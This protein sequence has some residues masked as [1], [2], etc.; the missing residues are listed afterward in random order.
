MTFITRYSY[1]RSERFLKK[2]Y[3]LERL[4]NMSMRSKT[5]YARRLSRISLISG[6]DDSTLSKA[7]DVDSGI[8]AIRYR[9]QKTRKLAPEDIKGVKH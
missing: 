8:E 5:T 7:N 3:F 2:S 6:N 1:K 9:T 4:K